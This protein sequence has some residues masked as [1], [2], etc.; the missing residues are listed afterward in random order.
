VQK[1]SQLVAKK[2]LEMTGLTPQSSTTPSSSELDLQAQIAIIDNIANNGK[3]YSSVDNELITYFSKNYDGKHN[4][5]DVV[6]LEK[7]INQSPIK[8]CR[9][10]N[11][12]IQQSMIKPLINN[13]VICPTSS[14]CDGMGA[15]G[16]CAPPD[17]TE[18]Y[19]MDFMI[20]YDETEFY[21]GKTTLKDKKTMVSIEYGFKFG[22]L[23]LYNFLNDINIKNNP[24][25]LLQA[26][27]TFKGVINR[28]LEIWKG[29]QTVTDIEGLW[30]L[31]E[32]DAFF[33][34]ILQVGSQKA[35]GDIFQEV[36]STLE[37]GGYSKDNN[38][39]SEGDEI[40]VINR[41]R[42]FGVMGDRPSG[43][44]VIKLLK[45]GVSGVKENACGGYVAENGSLIYSNITI[46]STYDQAAQS[47]K[48]AIKRK[49][50]M[51]IKK[52]KTKTN[53]RKKK[54]NKKRK[55]IKKSKKN[56]KNTKRFAN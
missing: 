35:V 8:N 14:V 42:T 11:N 1:I 18:Y 23:Q 45:D 38:D 10:I 54:N 16:S 2:T 34:S 32:N 13:K 28:I 9:V 51:T 27:Y 36:N 48:A 49:G 50:G 7:L 55:S 19:N 39:P 31:L 15:F 24:V 37:Y 40:D 21:E 3:G 47:K 5:I 29:A 17:N 43:I 52:I 6:N 22:N 56:N 44:R 20:S 12:A 46:P 4:F 41:K 26:N 25:K 33:L 53:T 30:G